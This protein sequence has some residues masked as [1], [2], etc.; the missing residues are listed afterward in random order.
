MEDTGISEGARFL[1]AILDEYARQENSCWPSQAELSERFGI[2]SRTVQRRIA[3]LETAGMIECHRR[4][5]AGGPNEYVLVA[6]DSR[7]ALPPIWRNPPPTP[8]TSGGTLPPLVAEP[9]GP[10]LN[11]LL[12]QSIEEH[13]NPLPPAKDEELKLSEERFSELEDGYD[14]HMKFHRLEPR[15]TILQMLMDQAHRGIFNWVK[16]RSNHAGYC[17]AQE[18]NGW[19]FA[20]L[21]FMSWVRAGMPPAAKTP[22]SIDRRRQ[23]DLGEMLDQLDREEEAKFNDRQK[24]SS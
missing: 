8:A 13:K 16:F 3:E 10:Y 2:S 11:T 15:D 1:Y 5:V 6:R 20:S 14:R 19:N 21:T 18:R 24:K 12:K 17:E 7:Q 4:R 9:V 22:V 23:P